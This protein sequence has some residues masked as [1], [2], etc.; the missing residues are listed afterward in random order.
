MN[1]KF[2]YLDRGLIDF[3]NL[4]GKLLLPNMNFCNQR[5][6]YQKIDK[7][8]LGIPMLLNANDNRFYKKNFFKLSE[9]LIQKKIFLTKNRNYIPLKNYLKK[10]NEYCE[11]INVKKKFFKKFQFILRYN[12]SLINYIKK[13]KRKK[14]KICSFQT[15]NI[16]HLG[17]EEIIK[18]ILNFCDH[19]VINPII[20]L[21]KSGDINNFFL[22]KSFKFLI[23]K[24]FKNK[25]SF[26][27]LISNMFYAGPREALHHLVVRQNLGFDYFSIGRDHAG[28]FGQYKPLS[29][30]NLCKKLS[31]NFKIK[32]IYHSG[33][34]Y[35]E[36]C[37]KIII[38]NTHLKHKKY[39][40]NISGSEF[41][42]QLQKKKIYKY[43][44]PNLQ[45]YLFNFKRSFFIQ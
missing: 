33:A 31:K 17:H 9:N 28:A 5:V 7:L 35:C 16:P 27:P 26:F 44:D 41:R 23:K 34:Y 21:R 29:A 43:A 14:L 15:R 20:G 22:N 11:P 36:K 10:G 39:F 2:N 6:F 19:V 24:K 18:Y 25:V 12:Q 1:I 8:E 13:L 37:K 32:T 4:E 42:K 45:R 3:A 40:K 30:V 38:S